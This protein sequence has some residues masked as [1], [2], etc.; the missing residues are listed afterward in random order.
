ML[1]D[2]L[3]EIYPAL[4]NL[5]GVDTLYCLLV[6]RIVH[7]KGNVHSF[8]VFKGYT[9]MYFLFWAVLLEKVYVQHKMAANC[10]GCSVAQ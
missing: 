5:F 8:S 2:H 3:E 10:L 6:N 9:Y 1:Y 7:N 4:L